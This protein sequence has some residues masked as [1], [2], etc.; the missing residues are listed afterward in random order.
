MRARAFLMPDFVLRLRPKTLGGHVHVTFWLAA[1]RPERHGT[2]A[3][4]GVLTFRDDEWPDVQAA[5]R[6]GGAVHVEK[7]HERTDPVSR[8]PEDPPEPL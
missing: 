1:G 8:L 7:I 3:Q 4:C 5:F 2:F 6:H